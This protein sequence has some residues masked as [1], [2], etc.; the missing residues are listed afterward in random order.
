VWLKKKFPH[1]LCSL[2]G[3]ESNQVS[4]ALSSVLFKPYVSQAFLFFPQQ[5]F[6]WNY[7]P[8]DTKGLLYLINSKMGLLGNGNE[9]GGG[10][11]E[12]GVQERIEGRVDKIKA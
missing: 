8:V 7:M 3:A 12:R 10:V 11:R 6:P 2:A 4:L 5:W 9:T 1:A